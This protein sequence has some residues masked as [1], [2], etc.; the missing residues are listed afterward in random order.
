MV[1]GH[2]D[3]LRFINMTGFQSVYQFIGRQIDINHFIGLFEYAK[4]CIRDSRVESVTIL[5]DASAKALYGSKA[6]NGVVVIETK[7][8][9]SGQLRV[10]YNGSCLL[11]TSFH[12]H[13]LI[14]YFKSQSGIFQTSFHNR[15]HIC[16]RHFKIPFL[17]VPDIIVTV[18]KTHSGLFFHLFEDFPQRDIFQFDT[19]PLG[20]HRSE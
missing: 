8:L 6:A 3:F 16:I 19:H 2:L 11:Y 17:Q 12:N 4:M 9:L 14:H 20:I 1:Q 5:K 13:D 18:H 10:T 7:R 15:L